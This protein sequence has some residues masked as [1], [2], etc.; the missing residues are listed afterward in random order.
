VTSV[1][2]KL[3]RRP[4]NAVASFGRAR[5]DDH[6]EPSWG[7]I[8]ETRAKTLG[9][10]L[11]KLKDLLATIDDDPD[12]PDWEIRMLRSAITDLESSAAGSAPEE[13]ERAGD[14]SVEVRP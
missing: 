8:I 10:V 6:A 4:R 2:Q 14:A 7:H 1:S 13:A 5:A 12:K 11:W 9:G 3:A